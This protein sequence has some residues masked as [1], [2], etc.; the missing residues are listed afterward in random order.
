MDGSNPLSTFPSVLDNRHPDA[1]AGVD[2]D[3][4]V[5]CGL[6]LNACPT[7]RELGVEMD[8]PRGRIYQMVQVA[9]GQVEAGPSYYEHLDLCL[10]C[11]SCESACP[12][13]VPY[14]RLIEA[15][16]AEIVATRPQTR[17]ERLLRWFVYRR[18]LPSRVLMKIFGAMLY[19][20]EASSLRRI[21]QG[22][23]V[24]KLMGKLGRVEPLAPSAE[25]PFFFDNIGR[26]FPAIGPK[27][28]RVAFHAGCISNVFFA[29][30]NEATV[31]VLQH[32]GCEVVIPE[33][34]C[35]CGALHAH[36]GERD[37]A[38][39]LARRNIDAFLTSGADAFVT[40]T[41]G[42]GATLK[43]YHELLEHD[44][45]YAAKSRRFVDQMRD[46]LEF[47]AEIGVAPG[48]AMMPVTVTY[49]DSCHLLHGQKIR[50]APRVLLNAI[51]GV[52][53]RELPQSE[54]CCGSAGTYNVV[55][56]EM[57]AALLETKMA[58]VNLTRAQIL[59][60]ANPGCMIQLRAG[61]E[62]HGQ[63]QRVLHVIEL[64][65]EAYRKA[66]TPRS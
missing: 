52:Q 55:H 50:N 65:D 28:A 17:S 59:T 49:Q 47:L 19:L 60:T 57:A 10:G 29:R 58:N 48:M 25:A 66:G 51:P 3:K 11:R 46:V 63:G 14:G 22:S 54:I 21:V 33:K 1:P 44:P 27:R 32:N 16:R 5:H 20:Y 30:L 26:V 8:S 18:L 41:A 23:G 12:S 64:L 6:C 24:L 43:E 39:G 13:G 4:C 62:R 38:R 2:L 35:C 31:R 7:Y 15:A 45:D 40:N 61:V 56:D 42:C 53:L 34:Q 37:L 9:T 36:A